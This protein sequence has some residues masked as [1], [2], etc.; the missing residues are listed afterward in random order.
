MTTSVT[1]FLSKPSGRD[2]IDPAACAY[3]RQRN[4]G[5]MYNLV[6]GELEKSALYL[7]RSLRTG[8]VRAKI[9]FHVG[10]V[11]PVTGLQILTATCFSQSAERSLSTVYSILWTRP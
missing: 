5:H 11:V 4:K 2:R 9:K 10:L 8:L 7:K 3:F 6:I 1:P